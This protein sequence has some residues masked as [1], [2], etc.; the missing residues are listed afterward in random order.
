MK[1]RKIEK[2]KMFWCKLL[3]KNIKK[4]KR[5]KK[6]KKVRKDDLPVLWHGHGWTKKKKVAHVIWNNKYKQ[7]Y[8]KSRQWNGKSAL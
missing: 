1:N 3:L 6:K 8:H 7:W 2:M 4:K 5:K